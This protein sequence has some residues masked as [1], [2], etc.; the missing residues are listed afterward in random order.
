MYVSKKEE[1]K[2]FLENRDKIIVQRVSDGVLYHE[3][4]DELFVNV[5][6]VA[7]RLKIIRD[8]YG[9]KSTPHLVKIFLQKGFIQ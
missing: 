4:A 7:N 6:T 1:T 9:A 3:I 8:T 5:T 2:Q